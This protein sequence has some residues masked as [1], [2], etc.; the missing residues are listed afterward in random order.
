[1]RRLGYP[2]PPFVRDYY[3]R[4]YLMDEA[5]AK[6]LEPAGVAATTAAVAVRLSRV[7]RCS[8]M[9]TTRR[10]WSS[11]SVWSARSAD[12]VL[13]QPQLHVARQSPSAIVSPYVV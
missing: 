7:G 9:T 5:I 3:Q 1:V 10:C 6:V 13:R 2:E 12:G 11:S 8:A 4:A